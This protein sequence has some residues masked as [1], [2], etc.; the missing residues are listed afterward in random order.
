MPVE[1]VLIVP[2]VEGQ[3]EEAA[4]PV[5]LRRFAHDSEVYNYQ[6]N[7]PIRIKVSSFLQG[8]EYF[9]R[10]IKLAANKAAMSNG[11]VLILLDCE[12]DCP[13]ELGPRL[14]QQAQEV[15]SDVEYLCVLAYR[16]FETWFLAAAE[17]LSGC[18]GLNEDLLPM[19]DPESRRD[20]KGWFTKNMPGTSYDPIRHQAAFASQFSFEQA[21]RVPSFHRLRRKLSE[22]F[23]GMKSSKEEVTD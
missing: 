10:F 3:G 21:E 4:V 16:E 23:T 7:P 11:L 5:L 20:A 18:S 12:D 2:I 6:I 9:Q 1:P 14:L 19:D 8:G 22:Y 17:S 15:R 13:A